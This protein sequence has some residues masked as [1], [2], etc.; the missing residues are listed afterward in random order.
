MSTLRHVKKALMISALLLLLTLSLGGGVASKSNDQAATYENLRLFTEVLSIIQ[1]QYVDEVP[2]KDLVYSAIKGT[3]RGLDAHSSFLDPDMYREMGVETTGQFG[4]LG[5]EITLKDDIL[6][7]VAPIEGTPAFR[8]GILPGDRIVKIEGMSTKDMQ[9]SDAVKR[10][11]GK[12]GSKI[13]ISIVR[14][15][16][17]EPKDYSI[18]RELIQ[19][20]SVKTGELEPGIEYIRLRQFQ[21]KTGQDVEGALEKYNK[22]KKIQ[23]L[24]LDL[25]NNP[26]GLL[27]SSVEVTEKFLESGKL[28][29]YTEGRVRN[30][31]MR[32]QAAGKRIWSDFP[33][34]VLVNQGSASASEIVAG[35]LQDW[36]RAVVLGTQS[37]GKGSVQT[38][39]PLSDGSGL[40]LT[41]AK[42]FTPKGRSI[43]GKG[44]TPD[45]IVE[46]P[47]PAAGEQAP[48]PIVDEQARL[49]DQLKRDPQLQR[50]V[51]LLKAMKI[52]DK[53]TRPAGTTPQV[54]VR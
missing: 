2:P 40:R 8:A 10:M 17:T 33:I 35:A 53:T 36:G 6:T 15:G 4:G 16:L 13:V 9:L 34:I 52:M 14:E 1:S 44:I 46:M 38:I 7:V 48:P 19:V 50:A 47:K 24:V 28:V 22:G 45:I 39:I 54:S 51:D 3:L 21:E 49:Q 27:T 25:R 26:G 11:R 41:T 12:P 20:Q 23:G 32:F 31:N 29:V 18:T 5:I 42:Y 37:F 43:H 30:Q